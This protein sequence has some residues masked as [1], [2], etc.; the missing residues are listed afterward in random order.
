MLV[1]TYLIMIGKMI[2][3]HSI[4]YLVSTVQVRSIHEPGTQLVIRLVSMTIMQVSFICTT[5]NRPQ[6]V[7]QQDDIHLGYLAL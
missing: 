4:G 3:I 5:K 2:M 7:H 6:A 1:I